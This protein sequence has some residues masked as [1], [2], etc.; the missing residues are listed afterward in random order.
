MAEPR[1]VLRGLRKFDTRDL[2]AGAE[3]EYRES[4]LEPEAQGEVVLFTAFV[5]MSAVT[6]VAAFLLR[7][8][9][10]EVF[11]EDIE[12]QHPDGRVET[13]HIRLTRDHVEAPKAELIRQIRGDWTP[14]S[15]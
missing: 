12:I 11:E 6:A 3:I 13:R 8:H 2:G 5:A 1:I 10:S 15:C 7:K 4:K 9:D 14:T